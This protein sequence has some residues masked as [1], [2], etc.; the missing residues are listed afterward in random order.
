MTELTTLLGCR[1]DEYWSFLLGSNF[2][3]GGLFVATS[4]VLEKL[5]K[6]VDELETIT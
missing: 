5:M 3:D 1:Y 2:E 4:F 6:D